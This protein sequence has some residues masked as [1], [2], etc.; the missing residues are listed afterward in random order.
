MHS[1]V[2]SSLI[3]RVIRNGRWGIYFNVVVADTK[4]LATSATTHIFSSCKLTIPTSIIFLQIYV[5]FSILS[6]KWIVQ[7][8]NWIELNWIE[9]EGEGIEGRK[10]S[11]FT[12]KTHHTLSAIKSSHA[13]WSVQELASNR[14]AASSD[15]QTD[16]KTIH[17]PNTGEK[18]P[19]F[20]SFSSAIFPSWPAMTPTV[21]HTTSFS[22]YKKTSQSTIEFWVFL[23]WICKADKLFPT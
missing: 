18:A 19:T 1:W 23:I 11:W 4:A 5:I 7:I 21:C 22:G 10:P 8:K 9:R 3:E 13:L 20:Q 16:Q 12:G 6:V 17:S 2:V 15:R 14:L